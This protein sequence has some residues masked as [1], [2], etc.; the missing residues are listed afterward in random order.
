MVG[1][2][3]HHK[4]HIFEMDNEL[5]FIDKDSRLISKILMKKHGGFFSGELGDITS[6]E[7]KVYHE[8]S[9]GPGNI[10]PTKYKLIVSY[11]DFVVD[12]DNLT[13]PTRTYEVNMTYDP[14]GNINFWDDS[15]GNWWDSK[16]MDIKNPYKNVWKEPLMGGYLNLAFEC[17]SKEIIHLLGVYQETKWGINLFKESS[18]CLRKMK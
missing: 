9:Y 2:V 5:V 13:P 3:Q 10:W 11:I 14:K 6:W 16:I 4:Y 17:Y 8:F 15:D 7:H 1:I 18:A 12:G